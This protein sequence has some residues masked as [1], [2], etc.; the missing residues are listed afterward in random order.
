[1]DTIGSYFCKCKDGFSRPTSSGSCEGSINCIADNE[2]QKA[3]ENLRL[4]ISIKFSELI[5]FILT[6][7]NGT[8]T[9]SV[10]KT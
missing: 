8:N 5:R 10:K 3:R 6:F 4:Q 7:G 9:Y 1:M 2:I